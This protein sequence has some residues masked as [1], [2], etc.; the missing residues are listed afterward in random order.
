[1]TKPNFEYAEQAQTA[2]LLEEA[3]SENPFVAEN[4]Y[5]FGY[6][7]NELTQK[8]SFF[9][10]LILLFT[11]ELPSQSQASMLEKLFISLCNL[12]PRH[13]GVRAG[14]IAG[15]SKAN[16]SNLLAVGLLASS[17]EKDGALE[18]EQAM[19]FIKKYVGQKI[20]ITNPISADEERFAPGF[21]SVYGSI[22]K[23]VEQLSQ[24]LSRSVTVSS[25]WPCLTWSTQLATKLKPQQQSL[26]ASGL[27]AAVFCDLGIGAR[28]GIALYQLMIAPGIAA[29]AMEQTH[30]PITAI[31]LLNDDSYEIDTQPKHT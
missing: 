26:L 25:E 14:M 22:D 30:K 28:E 5:L 20:E 17:G 4:T 13:D 23:R 1:M 9:D 11:G 21:G 10:T 8:K 3:C 7:I 6:D 27:C 2:I 24:I 19:L 16:N 29:H 12:G 31:P 15:V 18:V